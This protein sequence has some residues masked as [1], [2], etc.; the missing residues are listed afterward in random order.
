MLAE[1]HAAR[2]HATRNEDGERE[3]PD[4]IE[5]EDSRISYDS[6]DDT[7]CSCRVHTDFPPN[8]HDDASALY[9]ERYANDG[10]EEVRHVRDG[11]D[12]H[13]AQ[14]A[15]YINNVGNSAFVPLAQLE[16]APSV[17]AAVDEDAQCWQAKREEIDERKDP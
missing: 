5:V 10:R 14:V 4:G 9:E 6:A 8:V 13:E 1:H 17:Q 15:A 7:A 16:A 12:V 2:H 3:P 11:E